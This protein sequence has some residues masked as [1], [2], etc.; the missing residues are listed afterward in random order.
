MSETDAPSDNDSVAGAGGVSP[1][2]KLTDAQVFA[3]DPEDYSAESLAD[4]IARLRKIVARQRK[5]RQDDA[6][7]AALAAKMKKSNAAAKRKKSK[8]GDP[9]ETTIT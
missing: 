8:G 5:A 4:A 3:C 2:S 9:M 7:V 1:L 6:E